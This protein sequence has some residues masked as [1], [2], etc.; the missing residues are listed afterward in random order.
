MLESFYETAVAK[1]EVIKI[2]AEY[3]WVDYSKQDINSK[4]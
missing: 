4:S 3:G 2:W 1:L